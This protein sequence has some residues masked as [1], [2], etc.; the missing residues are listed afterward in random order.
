MRADAYWAVQCAFVLWYVQ[1][2]RTSH[3]PL[4]AAACGCGAASCFALYLAN[5]QIFLAFFTVDLAYLVT[6]IISPLAGDLCCEI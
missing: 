4:S 6:A 1:D 5:R 3:P 2:E